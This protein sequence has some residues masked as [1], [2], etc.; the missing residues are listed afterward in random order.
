MSFCIAS[1]PVLNSFN[2]SF[3]LLELIVYA[4]AFS[5]C[6]I[7]IEALRTIKATKVDFV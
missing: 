6:I 5:K 3:G 1:F 7:E 4:F 2:S